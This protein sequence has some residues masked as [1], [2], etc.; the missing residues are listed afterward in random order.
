MAKEFHVIWKCIRVIITV[1]MRRLHLFGPGDASAPGFV[2]TKFSG[3]FGCSSSNQG[4]GTRLVFLCSHEVSM[5]TD[6]VLVHASDQGRFAAPFGPW[7]D[8][9]SA[10]PRSMPPVLLR[11]QI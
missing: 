9:S 2:Y 6:P 5:R 3:S 8:I 7:M 4:V 11:L 1:G 10:P